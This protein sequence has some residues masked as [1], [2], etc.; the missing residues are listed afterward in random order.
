MSDDDILDG[1][2]V[3]QFP[4]SLVVVRNDDDV[5]TLSGDLIH[6]FESETI[7]HVEVA[8]ILNNTLLEPSSS[9]S[10]IFKYFLILEFIYDKSRLQFLLDKLYVPS[11]MSLYADRTDINLSF[12]SM[13]Q[14]MNEFRGTPIESVTTDELTTRVSDLLRLTKQTLEIASMYRSYGT[15]H[16]AKIQDVPSEEDQARELQPPQKLFSFLLQ[17]AGNKR[18]R[19][20]N[21]AMY[22]P[23]ILEDGTHTGFYEYDSEIKDFIFASTTPARRYTE[24]Y[25]ILTN[26]PVTPRHMND[27]LTHIPDTRCPFLHKERTLFSYRNGIFDA[28]TGMIHAH[29]DI[30]SNGK[31]TSQFFD[32]QLD[33]T[34]LHGNP[35]DIDT[36]SFDKILIDQELDQKTRFWVYALCGRLL[37]DVGT[38]DDWQITLFIR[39][40]AGSGKST[41]LNVMKLMYEADDIGQ[42]MSDG[43]STFSDE[44]LYDKNIIMAMD[45]D[46]KCNMSATRVNSMT[47]G[48]TLSV[49]RKFKTALNIKWKPPMVLASN[50][51]PPWEDV[52]GN[53]VRR[54]AIFLFNNPVRNSDPTLAFKLKTEAP[55][56]LVKISRMYLE[57]LRMHGDKSLWEKDVLPDMCHQAKKKYLVATNPLSAFLES[58]TV[59]FGPGLETPGP[60]FKRA[61]A[62]Y[63]KEHG[64]RRAPIGVIS[65][66]DHGHIFGMYMCSIVERTLPNRTTQVIIRG[67]D[68]DDPDEM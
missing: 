39:G 48:E 32:F 2:I 38:M 18:L 23:M 26:K 1:L 27:L 36:P 24:F 65:K 53:L 31:C 9:P 22:R 62:M 43:Q 11:R 56:I 8:D 15:D 37:H 57:A 55:M 10:C 51:Q 52:A 49:N 35:M 17:Q 58:E 45:I 4:A 25:D 47:S 30:V 44:H 64:D 12:L 34:Y 60:K 13:C 42:L 54:F 3:Q 59:T 21:A 61:L 28:K 40:V 33:D 14:P 20:K 41:I 63:S 29:T 6:T 19:R 5:F 7:S 16:I 67:L 66:V 46:K 68:I 50:S